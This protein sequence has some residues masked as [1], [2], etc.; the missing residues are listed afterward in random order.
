[1]Y[2]INRYVWTMDS[3]IYKGSL[4]VIIL[5]LLGE[6]TEMYGYQITK[7][8][9]EIS[10]GNIEIKEGSLYPLLHRMEGRGVITSTLRTEGNRPRKY[11]A[12]SKDGAKESV[13]LM[14]EMNEYIDMMQRILNPK[15]A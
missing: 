7:A 2:R 8:V 10:D 6:H 15:L 4:E 14:D 3:K 5:K 1:M 9:K 12:L 13:K 11:Y